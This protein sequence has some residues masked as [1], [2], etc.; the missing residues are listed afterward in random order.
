MVR[1]MRKVFSG[2]FRRNPLFFPERGVEKPLAF[3]YNYKRMISLRPLTVNGGFAMSDQK[4]SKMLIIVA[5]PPACGKTFAAKHLAEL[6]KPI[7]YLDKDTVL[8]LA[9]QV[10]RVL[11]E[12]VNRS[13]ATHEKYLRDVEGTVTIDMAL[14]ALRYCD[15]CIVNAPFSRELKLNEAKYIRYM[16][17]LRV[18]LE[19]MGAQLVVVFI[20][21]N[22]ETSERLMRYRR[23]HEGCNRDEHKLNDPDY[24][25]RTNYDVPKGLI[26]Y[27]P[28]IFNAYYVVSNISTAEQFATNLDRLADLLR[29]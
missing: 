10:F 21:S 29:A 3:Y 9:H 18:R 15:R 11:G 19:A 12:E 23:E 14:N 22:A 28:V 20:K 25:K 2:P 1:C 13:G 24:F 17:D 27:T 26:E 8:P 5:A 4:A 16:A 7:V 6:L